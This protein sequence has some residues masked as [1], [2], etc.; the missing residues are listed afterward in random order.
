MAITVPATGTSNV[1]SGS[2]TEA[3]TLPGTSAQDD[4]YVVVYAGDHSISCSAATTAGWSLIFNQ[5][6][7]SPGHHVLWKRMGASPDTTITFERDGS[8]VGDVCMLQFKGVDTTTA[9]DATLASATSGSGMPDPPSY[10]TVT[11]NAFRIVTG[12]LDD[13]DVTGIT[14]TGY[15]IVQI[16]S[17]GGGSTCMVGYKDAGTAGAEDPGAFSGSGSDA[18]AATHFALRPAVADP[19]TRSPPQTD[20]IL[21]TKTPTATV[22]SHIRQKSYRF[23]ND[24]AMS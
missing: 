17:G 9:I 13:V 11:N 20:L 8:Y 7:D 4:V 6:D 5:A 10:T 24:G 23:R 22:P 18:W 3:V 15:T 2:G 16:N 21:D 19:I 12:G 14:L 1:S